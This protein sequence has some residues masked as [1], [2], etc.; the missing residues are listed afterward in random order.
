MASNPKASVAPGCAICGAPVVARYRPFCSARCANVDLGR[1]LNAY[2]M[3]AEGD[4]DD[5]DR[6][7][8]TEA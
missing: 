1:W 4:P 6:P 7:E 3:P 8:P 5:A 2:V